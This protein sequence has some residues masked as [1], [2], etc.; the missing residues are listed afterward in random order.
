MLSSGGKFPLVEKLSL[1]DALR[2]S[3]LLVLKC[4]RRIRLTGCLFFCFRE[5]RVFDAFPSVRIVIRRISIIHL[6][7]AT[8]CFF[9]ILFC[10]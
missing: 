4:K 7:D 2:F 5:K 9:S 10:L 6:S 1:V 3:P 8:P